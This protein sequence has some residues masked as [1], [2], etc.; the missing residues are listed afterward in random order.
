MAHA[1]ADIWASTPTVT[2]NDSE[3]VVALSPNFRFMLSVHEAEMLALGIRFALR[4]VERQRLEGG[5][6]QS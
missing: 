5:E 2:A 6:V 3:V 1:H 4:E